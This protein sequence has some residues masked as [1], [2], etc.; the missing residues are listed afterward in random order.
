MQTIVDAPVKI[1][2]EKKMRQAVAKV[3]GKTAADLLRVS[4]DSSHRYELI[5]GKIITMSPAGYKHGV[6]AMRLGGR[7]LLH[8]EDNDL[9]FVF[10]AETGFQ[11]TTKPDTVRAPDVAFVGKERIPRILVSPI[12]PVRRIWQWRS[13]H[14]VIER[15]K[16]KTRC[17][18][19]CIMEQSWFGWWNRRRKR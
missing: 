19:G 14:P 7:M 1:Q 15:M 18:P 2:Q 8:A 16:C 12:S 13:F 10:A 4:A 5:Q 17:K 9:G 11:L 6:F 3:A